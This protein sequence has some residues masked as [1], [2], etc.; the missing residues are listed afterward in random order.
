MVKVLTLFGWMCELSS[1]PGEATISVFPWKSRGERW[2]MFDVC[3]RV[4]VCSCVCVCVCVCE[5]GFSA[6][7]SLQLTL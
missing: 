1:R 7:G 4:C 2:R 5:S 3:V 6:M